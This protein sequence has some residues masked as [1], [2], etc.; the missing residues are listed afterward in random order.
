MDAG[1]PPNAGEQGRSLH[2]D[3]EP[4][5]SHQQLGHYIGLSRMSWASCCSCLR[6]EVLVS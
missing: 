3:R 1:W 4:V 2:D 5:Q 6:V